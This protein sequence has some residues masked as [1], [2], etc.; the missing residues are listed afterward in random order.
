MPRPSTYSAA[1]R[2]RYVAANLARAIST[3]ASDSPRYYLAIIAAGAVSLALN[4]PII[5]AYQRVYRGAGSLKWGLFLE[6]APSQTINIAARRRRREHLSEGRRR[7]HHVRADGAV[8][9]L[10]H[11]DAAR[12]LTQPGRA[13]RGALLGGARRVDP[14]ARHP[15][16]AGGAPRR[17]RRAVRAGHG[18][19]RRDGRAGVRARAHGRPAPR[20]RPFRAV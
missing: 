7:W 14:L 9:V 15:R 17:R 16:S 13:V 19:Q 11:G 2:R 8:R 4:F 20:H 5:V 1:W 6:Y 3:H 18:P 10:L 12:A